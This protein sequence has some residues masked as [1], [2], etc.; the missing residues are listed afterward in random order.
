QNIMPIFLDDNIN[1]ELIVF[2]VLMILILQY[3]S[4]GLWSFLAQ[5]WEFIWQRLGGKPLTNE[6][7]YSALQLGEL[8]SSDQEAAVKPADKLSSRDGLEHRTLPPADTP[9]LELNQLR[10]EFGGL[11]AVNDLSFGIKAGEIVGLI[12]PN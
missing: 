6:Q 9:V 5:G 3:A 11:V 10:K 7:R 8:T 2:G 1:A 12:G 4:Q